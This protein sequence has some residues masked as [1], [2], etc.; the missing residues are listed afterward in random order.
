MEHDK[1]HPGLW[2]AFG[3]LNGVDFWRNK[4]RIEHVHFVE[5]P[6]VAEG[7]L[8]FSVEEK[9]VA[10]DGAEVCRGVNRFR[11]STS[12]AGNLLVWD[13]TVR[14]AD[15]PLTFGPQH[16]MGMGFRVATPLCV[17]GGTGG[18]ASSH[19]GKDEA[20]NWGRGGEWWDYT[21]EIAGRRAGILV[22]ASSENARPVWAHARDYGFLA[23]NPTGPP[24]GAKDVP[25]VPFT[26]PAGREFKSRAAFLLHSTPAAEKWDAAV[27]GKTV[28]AMMA[29]AVARRPH[30]REFVFPLLIIAANVSARGQE[31][32]NASPPKPPPLAQTAPETNQTRGVQRFKQDRFAI[33]LWVDPPASAD[34]DHRYAELAKANFSF[35]IGN[36]GA[37]TPDAIFRQ[38]ELC[39]KH[40]LKAIVSLGGQPPDQLPTSPAC[41]GYYL[42]DEPGAGAFPELRKS[43]DAIRGARPG[44]LAYINLFPNYCPPHALGTPTYEEHVS[45]FVAEVNP[46]VLSM[47]HYPQFSPTADGREDYCQ[48]LEVMRRHSLA[49]GIPFWNF[50]NTMPYGPHTDPTEAQL[51]WQIFTSLSYGAKGVMYFCYW[52]PVG[53][54]FPKG[55]AIIT[56]DGRQTRHYAEAQR[57]NAA[58]KNLGPTLMQLTNSAVLRIKPKVDSANAL[59]DTAL[60]SI[61]DG[62]YLIGTFKHADGRR[63]VLLN[64]YH[65]AYSAWPTVAFDSDPAKVIEVSPKTGKETP[66]V[67]DSP[68]MPGLQVSL[69][70]GEGRL[71]LLP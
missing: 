42:A 26:I 20:G 29:P 12:D 45:R 48:N 28:S 24:P 62:D 32:K 25:S 10:P 17:K 67:D 59:K 13:A 60:R 49:A 16:E 15:G 34:L 9:Y 56:R 3:D 70:A 4:G 50:F 8:T 2:M 21:G 30:L 5:E 47:D 39:E 52:T 36:F 46:D 31:N 11:F 66:I 44:K 55:G 64:N 53:A 68:D 58:L 40:G 35:I 41:W 7:A 43:V 18:I 37:S 51:R 14:P 63:A 33:G 57:L 69:D 1:L 54:E 71:F 6:R 22:V 19:G 27:A 23:I 38:L 65:F 61:S